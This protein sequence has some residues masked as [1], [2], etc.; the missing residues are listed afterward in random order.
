[1]FSLKFYVLKFLHKRVCNGD[2]TWRQLP[3]VDSKPQYDCAAFGQMHYRTFDGKMYKF[4]GGKCQYI[5]MSDCKQH[6]NNQFCDLLQANFNVRIRNTRCVDSYEQYMC[7]EVTVEL[8]MFDGSMAEIVMLQ[9]NVVVNHLDTKLSFRKG[10]Y[11]QPRTNVIDGVEI[12]KVYFKSKI[13]FTFD[14]S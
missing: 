7:K 11:P 14:T 2:R 6:G 4:D 13:K 10:N 8:R 9:E 5:M 12:F 1:M 3:G